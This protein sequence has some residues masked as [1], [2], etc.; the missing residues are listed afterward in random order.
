MFVLLTFC[1]F[2]SLAPFSTG[3]VTGLALALEGGATR[4]VV[5]GGVVT[6]GLVSD[7]VGGEWKK[8]NLKPIARPA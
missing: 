5:G 3:V 1:F 8:Y 4:V 2:R 6:E 7:D